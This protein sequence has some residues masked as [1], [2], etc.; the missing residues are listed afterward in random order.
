DI[1]I[2]GISTDVMRRALQQARD[3]RLQILDVMLQEL[4]G[5]RPELSPFAPRITILQIDPE[6]IGAVIGPGGKV[7]RGIQDKTGVKIDIENDGTI[8]VAAVDGPSADLAAEMIMNLIEEPE[9]GRIYT[10]KVTRIESYGA[11]VE[12]LPGREGMVHISQIA[13]Y[14][15]EKIE[16]EV[17]INDEVMVMVTDVGDGGRVRL[18]R[19]AVLEGWTIEEARSRD[20]GI[21]EGGSRGGRRGGGGGG[22]RR[23]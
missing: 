4:P 10:G 2:K 19:Q 7:V 5:P 23:R 22:N 18:S 14:R 9:L 12:F 15:V 21:S 20:K 11:F 17:H 16:D 13:D 1:K 6:K 8:F 3:A